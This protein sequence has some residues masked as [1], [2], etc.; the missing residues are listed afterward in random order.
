[1]FMF[2]ETLN[3]V[4]YLFEKYR[5]MSS[6]V[7]AIFHCDKHIIKVIRVLTRTY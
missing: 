4:W 5:M 6:N 2:D 1:M 3:K 7:S